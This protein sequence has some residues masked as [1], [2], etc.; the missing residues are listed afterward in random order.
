MSQGTEIPDIVLDLVE[1][2]KGNEGLR[3]R[4]MQ[5]SASNRLGINDAVAARTG[6]VHSSFEKLPDAELV[7]LTEDHAKLLYLISLYTKSANTNKEEEEWMRQIPLLVLT[8]ELTCSGFF[9]YDYAPVSETIGRSHIYMN[10]SQ[11]GKDDIDDL[12]EAGLLNGLKLSSNEYQSVTA[13]QI[14]QKGTKLLAT[15]AKAID[16]GGGVNGLPW[17]SEV[18][19]I[20]RDPKTKNLMDICW[21][22]TTFSLKGDSGFERVSNIT[23]PE[24]VSYVSSP[25]LPA[26]LRF[27]H[28]RELSSNAR[29]VSEISQAE[30]TMIDKELNEVITLG[31]V[32]VLVGEWC[33]FGSNHIVAMNDKLGSTERVQGGL[34]TALVDEQPS[35]TK[36]KLAPGLTSVSILEFDYSQFLN[37]EAEVNFPEDDGVLQIEQFGVH[38]KDDGM[39]C[40]GLFVDAIMDKLHDHVSLDHLSRLLIDVH[41]DS[42]SILESLLT[43]YQRRLLETLL[44]QDVNNREKFNM[45]VAKKITPRLAAEKYLDKEDFENELKQVI[46]DTQSATDVDDNLIIIGKTGMLV[47]SEDETKIMDVLLFF[48][49]M[50]GRRIILDRF[51]S[52]IFSL[53]EML[54]EIRGLI[55]N[56]EASPNSFQQIR[57][58]ISEVSKQSILLEE[59]L[60]YLSES[61]EEMVI[62][63]TNEGTIEHKTFVHLKVSK[64]FHDLK[65]RTKDLKKNMVGIHNELAAQREMSDS[66]K[67]VNML[68]LQE[69]MNSNTKNLEN[70]IRSN[71][72]AGSSLEV[73]QMVLSGTLAFEILDRLTGEWSILDTWWGTTYLKEPLIETPGIWFFINISLWFLVAFG[74]KVLMERLTQKSAAVLVVRI[75]ANVPLNKEN[76]YK[77]LAGKDLQEEEIG[78]EEKMLV[79]KVSWNEEDDA[80]WGGSAPSIELSFDSKHSYLLSLFL[81]VEKVNKNINEK[82]IKEI[83]WQ[84][85]IQ[86]GVVLKAESWE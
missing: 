52:R 45:I 63:E 72:R 75:K 49:S 33:P 17:R 35:A 18:D 83:I 6:S 21:D 54:K 16:D 86:N 44:G 30:S 62:P 41:Q 27:G 46:G 60:G 81:Q 3:K 39:V 67:E 56:H 4:T 47:I 23:N 55:L 74:L 12:R 50:T 7:D 32:K 15:A 38:V 43:S 34:F 84:D 76:L 14:S 9:G 24:D 28:T 42:S 61:F 79:K 37:F 57:N 48:A 53:Y 58:G 69:A 10:I 5:K 13:Y 77:F 73:M 80:K 78:M 65:R 64:I 66:I 36:F 85:L 8:Y 22:G 68:R 29:R 11:E 20:I 25:Y 19:D 26:S 71:E 59:V 82:N 70:V 31:D 40:Y 1:G 2:E 51:F